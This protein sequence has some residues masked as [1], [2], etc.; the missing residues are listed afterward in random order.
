MVPA[1]NPLN[2]VLSLLHVQSFVQFLH[3]EVSLGVKFVACLLRL[4]V[5]LALQLAAYVLRLEVN[6]FAKFA[7][8]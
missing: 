8:W 7:P 4:V 5:N 1:A 6:P 3:L 2:P